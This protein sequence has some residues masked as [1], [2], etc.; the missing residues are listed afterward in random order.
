MVL[1]VIVAQMATRF[2]VLLEQRL[3]QCEVGLSVEE[4][5]TTT[6]GLSLR[7]FGASALDRKAALGPKATLADNL[8]HALEP[9][10]IIGVVVWKIKG[11][12]LICQGIDAIAHAWPLRVVRPETLGISGD[13]D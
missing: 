12:S 9:P 6:T 5:A 7:T 8:L 2:D 13:I 3:L 4:V 11:L 10:W 1:G